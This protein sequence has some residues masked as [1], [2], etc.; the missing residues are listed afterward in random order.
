MRFPGPLIP[1]TLIKRYKRFLADAVLPSGETVTVH[2]ANP[3]AMTGLDTPGARIWLSKAANVAI[4]FINP[5]W[6]QCGGSV[7]NRLHLLSS[8]PGNMTR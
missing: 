8:I 4:A 2:C 7:S 1:A 6:T 5:G 3:G